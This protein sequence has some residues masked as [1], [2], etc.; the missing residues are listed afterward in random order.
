MSSNVNLNRTTAV[1]L[2]LHGREE[3][4]ALPDQKPQ[5]KERIQIIRALLYHF[6]A[7]D[8]LPGTSLPYVAYL[9]CHSVHLESRYN[10]LR[11]NPNA[12][13]LIILFGTYQ[14][15]SMLFQ[16]LR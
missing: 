8:C 10:R 12:V 6:L 15:L 3:L 4:T 14:R 2:A 7:F 13:I 5:E 16:F 11:Q 9:T 1:A